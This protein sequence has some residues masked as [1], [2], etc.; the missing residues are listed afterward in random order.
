MNSKTT[1]IFAPN[2]T[3]ITW[4]PAGLWSLQGGV[5]NLHFIALS[6]ALE[7]TQLLF[8]KKGSEN[9]GLT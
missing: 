1:V 4:A 3:E 9:I 8:D 2:Q 7:A 6:P 5:Q